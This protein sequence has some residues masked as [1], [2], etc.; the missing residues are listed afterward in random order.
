MRDEERDGAADGVAESAASEAP[1]RAELYSVD[2]LAERA[3]ELARGQDIRTKGAPRVTPLLGLVERADERFTAFQR[4]LGQAV[5]DGEPVPAATEW[6]LD[7]SYLIE[8]QIVRVREDLPPGYGEELPYLVSGPYESFPR[9][10]EAVVDLIRHT[11]GRIDEDYLASFVRG[12][13]SVSPMTIGETWAVPIML[14]AA[15]VE[16]VRRLALRVLAAYR[17]SAD[18][19]KW[20][21]RL[22]AAVREGEGDLDRLLA[23]LD[24]AT[25]DQRP[26]FFI[27][28]HQRL[29][30]QEGA[31]PLEDWIGGRIATLDRSIEEY[32]K[33]QRARQSADQISVANTI[34]SIRFL[35]ALDWRGFFEETSVVEAVLR[36]DP[37]GVYESMDFASRDRYRHAVESLAR[38]CPHDEIAV[39]EAAVKAALAAETAGEEPVRSHVGWH[40]ISGGRYALEDSLRYRPHTRERMHRGPLRRRGRTFMVSIASFTV[41]LAALVALYASAVGAAPWVVA[42]VFLIALVP[43]S[44]IAVILANRMAAMLWPARLL[45]KL[46]YR[47]PLEPNERTLVVVPTLLFSEEDA[48]EVFEHLEVHYLSG[49]GDPGIHYAVLADLRGADREVLD[50]DADI[51][52]AALESVRALNRRH[53]GGATA[54]LD[55]TGSG[56]FHLL[57]RERRYSE[58]EDAWIGWERKRGSLVELAR[59]LRSADHTSIAVHEGDRDFLAGVRYA[60]TL[61]AD[62]VLSRDAA[63]KMVGTIVH[64]LNQAVVDEERRVT[65]R[66]YGL[67]QPRVSV[68]LPSSKAT[69]F[70]WMHTGVAG[71]DPYGGAVSDAYQ[72]IFGEGSFTGKGLLDVDVFLE[73]LES[74]VPQERVL[75]HDLLEGSYMRT[76]LASDIEVFDDYP[77]RYAVQNSRNHRWTR[78]DWQVLPWILGRVPTEDGRE[79]NPLRPIHRWKMLDNLR[80]SLVPPLLL[81]LI[82]AGWVLL[83]DPGPLWPLIVVFIVMFPAVVQFVDSLVRRPEDVTFRGAVHSTLQDFERDAMRGLFA[84]AILP[85]QAWLMTDAIVRALWRSYV[86]RRHMLEWTTAAEAAKAGGETYAGHYRA[87]GPSILLGVALVLPAVFAGP[88]HA[89]VAIALS[90]LWAVSPVL[91]RRASREAPEAVRELD[92]ED[93]AYLR[94]LARRTWR[95]F[96][97]F[98][99]AEGHYLAPDNFQEDPKGE[100]A[101]RTSPTNIGLQLLTY[102]TAYDMGWIGPAALVDRASDTLATLAGMQ[103]FRGHFYN[104]YDT[105]TLDPLPPGYIS[106]VDSG[107]LAGHML[108][109]RTGLLGAAEE[110][111][112]GPRVRAGLH[113]PVALALEEV[114]RAH[115]G[116]RSVLR[117]AAVM[118]EEGAAPVTLSGW[119]RL[120]NDLEELAVEAEE[121]DGDVPAVADLLADVRGHRD[122]LRELAGFAEALGRV[123]EGIIHSVE[124]THLRSLLGRVPTL[125]ELAEG[126]E[127][128]E[129]ALET[130]E[131]DGDEALAAWAREVREGVRHSRE[132]ARRLLARLRLMAQIAREM[133]EHTDFRMLYDPSRKLFSIGFNTAEGRLDPSYYDMLASECRLASFLAVAKGDVPQAH[134]FRLGR[135]ITTTREGYALLSWSASMFEYLMPLLVMRDWEGTLLDQTYETVVR[136]QIQWGAEQR[137]P[138]GVSESAFNAKDIDLN[139]QYQAFG[140]PGLG[141]KRGLSEDVVIAPYATMLALM[142]APKRS[143]EN[144]HALQE[145]GALGRYGFYEA[146][147]Y[148]PGRIPAGQERALV[149]AY[150]AHHQG[151]GLVSIGNVLTG[152]R[153]QD[154]FH[155]DPLVRS[156]ELLLQER[157]PRHITPAHPHVEEVEY[158]HSVRELPPP[159]ERSYPTPHT[160]VPATQFLSNGRYSVMVTNAGGGFSRFEDMDVTRFRED[161][162]RDCW[163]TFFYLRDLDED[164]TWSA[165]YQPTLTEPDDYHVTFAADKVEFRRRDGDVETYTQVVVSPEDDVENRRIAVTNHGRQTRVIEVTSYFEIA[166]APSAADQAHRTFSNLFVETLHHEP[167]GAVLFSRR[168]RSSDEERPWGFHVLAC[169]HDGAHD[170]SF[171]T[172]R[173]RFLGRLRGVEEPRA[174]EDDH[175]LTGSVGAVLD[176]VCAVRHA[177]RIEPGDTAVLAYSTGVAPT[178]EDAEHLAAK[179]RDTRAVRRSLDLAWSANQIVLRDLGISAEDALTYQ[180][181]ASRLLL[182]DPYSP[183]KERTA[184]ENGLPM[185]GL[186]GLGV[187]GDMPILLVR[188]ERLEDTGIVRQALLAHQYWRYKGLRADLVILNTKPTAYADELEGRLQ[189]LVRTSHALQLQDKPGG[190]FIRR[191]DQMGADTR[192]LLETV[193]RAVLDGA[194]GSLE[195]QLNQRAERPEPVPDLVTRGEPVSRPAP[196]F[197]RPELAFDNG[198]GGFAPD[199]D[200][201]VIV[202]DGDRVPP[203]PWINVFANELEFGGMVTEAGVGTT[204]AINSHENRLTTWNNDAV[205]DGS[206]EHLYI[207]DEETGEY[208]SPTPLPVPDETPVVVR[209]ARGRTVFERTTHGI[210]HTATVSVPP[211]EPVRVVLLE[212]TNPTDRRRTLTATQF[213]EWSLGASRSQ[214]QHRVVTWFDAEADMLTA[215][216]HFNDDFPGR[217]TFLCADRPIDSYTASR[218]EFLGRNGTPDRP[219]ALAKAALSGRTGRFHDACGAVTVRLGVE[220]GHTTTVAFLLGQTDTLEEARELVG[221][222]RRADAAAASLERTVAWWD[223]FLDILSVRTP[224]DAL[225]RMINGRLLYQTLACRLWG[226]TALYQSS[227]A[228]GFRDQLQD[229]LAFDLARPELTRAQI[230][231]AA[232]HQFPEGDVLHWWMPVSGR[233][234]RTRITDDRHWLPYA[235]AHYL[236]VTGD[237]SILDEGIAYID[238]P[239]LDEGQE[240]LYLEPAVSERTASLYE[241]CVAALETARP[242]GPHGLPLIGG[243]DWNDGMNRVGVRGRGESV[244]LAWFLVH[245]LRRFTEVAEGRG[246]HERAADQ[247]LWAERL[248]DRVEASA[249]DGEWYRRAYFDDGTPLGTAD[250]RECRI[251]AIAQAWA[252]IVGEGDPARAT[253]ALDSADEYLVR[254][255]LGL[256]QLLDPPFDEMAHDPGYIKGYVPGVRENGGQYTHGVL[257][258]VLARLLRGEADR[259][260]ELLRMLTPVRHALDVE[261]A[262][263]FV[264]EPYAVVADV[265]TAEGHEGRGGWS[266]YTGSAGWFYRIAVGHLLGIRRVT[267][268]GRP[269]LLVDPRI[270]SDWDGFEATYRFEDARYDIRVRRGPGEIAPGAPAGS[271]V[272]SGTLDGRPLETAWLVPLE[273]DGPSEAGAPLGPGD[274]GR[275]GAERHA[276]DAARHAAGRVVEV[277]L[278]DKGASGG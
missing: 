26:E 155:A 241:H 269:H 79:R 220:P 156:A 247:R 123:P 176:P 277:L 213:V 162:T 53:G 4:E 59:Y 48:E 69:Y 128:S 5:R 258:L 136:R 114:P 103:R 51:I 194:E 54:G 56:P 117:R 177:V 9:V 22:L 141:L 37:A 249:W 132:A 175:G 210:E 253:R 163:G 81:L 268:E 251:D 3:A 75:S 55:D 248:V 204:W 183:L 97:T 205:S 227:G 124:A 21:R 185:S 15:L 111:I 98:V 116:V 206:G 161:V 24:R 121:A 144:L 172:D 66:G 36:D 18:A 28:L 2:R 232:R 225:D 112:V 151:M 217:A 131:A 262:D 212:L 137:T 221:R 105:R 252:A 197:E 74:R 106:T 272:V 32:W 265:Y 23:G 187:S 223:D 70:A 203:A 40:L 61:D 71:I 189:L 146:I 255:E 228:Y 273:T 126:L 164:R 270:P 243:G 99:T 166:L 158:V 45:P 84:L 25:A 199:A 72:D 115:E 130:M 237:E 139:Y 67:I 250:A 195:F 181:L 216:N 7:N 154:R 63:K 235:V 207:R 127:E 29:R 147:D 12:Y 86:S 100:V 191:A 91:A 142:V 254:E 34:T 76:A 159:T 278:S 179:Y 211:D 267:R 234:V 149:K 30:D 188:V 242:E 229:C 57:V 120:L 209:H 13:Q 190:V 73:T 186:W 152:D 16:N 20:A 275:T 88:G 94:R 11:D 150:M 35:D 58:T 148:T 208:W 257:W 226:R 87:M 33:A 82:A 219:E 264:V 93:E 145:R 104:W 39:A 49:D 233:G 256:I 31:E 101:F 214:A 218:T 167:T 239:P 96:Q 236:D 215:H 68:S 271:R 174:F 50:S 44:E 178:R 119:A 240:D 38:R 140:V 107:N 41:L 6:L 52:R 259:G 108:V 168:P 231:E 85:H 102:L 60:L 260:Y 109:L 193:A 83:P 77:V 1:M 157:V 138:W 246:D 245:T 192:I 261:A 125:R 133:W 169:E 180:R 143:V 43:V 266:W 10:Y 263:R 200:E 201:Y 173:A 110:P 238:G 95:F 184:V 78:G 244:W 135:S 62:T 198:Y 14:R 42:L 196:A 80:R 65:A 92:A 19:E 90:L 118:L 46:D 274:T 8:G 202:V 17:D 171:E 160:P 165:G 113:D 182:T 129:R 276:T 122:E 27:R 47:R 89:V 64:P 134:W 222:Y 170:S 230:V 224:D 153:M